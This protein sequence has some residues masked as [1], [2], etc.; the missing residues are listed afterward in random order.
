M[1]LIYHESHLINPQWLDNMSFHQKWLKWKTFQSMKWK[2]F[3]IPDLK[4]KNWNTSWS[5]QDILTIII[6]GNPN[7]TLPTLRKWLMTFIS[8]TPLPH[9]NYVQ[10]FLKAWYL[11]RLKTYV[12]QSIFSLTWKSKPKK[13]IVLWINFPT[14]N[15]WS[16]LIWLSYLILDCSGVWSYVQYHKVQTNTRYT[17]LMH[18]QHMHYCALRCSTVDMC[19]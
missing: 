8:Q 4:K 14:I 15:F 11:N 17:Y 18:G 7:Q 6:L 12:N 10:M 1:S 5:S 9:A 13:G 16:Y 3:S 19:I 2:K